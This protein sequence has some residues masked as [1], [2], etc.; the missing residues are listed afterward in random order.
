[1]KITVGSG[2]TALHYE[3]TTVGKDVLILVTG[4]VAHIGCTAV[5]DDGRLSV[6]TAQEHRDDSLAIPLA[7][8]ISMEFHCVCTVCAGFHLDSIAKD[9]IKNVLVNAEEGINQVIAGLNEI[10]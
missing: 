3:V 2:S 7:K 4:G 6:Y 1:M 9:D 10:K 8:I 5:G